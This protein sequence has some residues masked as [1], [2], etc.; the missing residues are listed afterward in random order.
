MTIRELSSPGPTTVLVVDDEEPILRLVDRVLK[1]A[2][3]VTR[4]ASSGADALAIAEGPGPLDV[5][6]TDMMMPEMNGD[7]VA[8]R[9]RLKHPA[10]QVLYCTGY[11]DHLFDEKGAMWEGEAFLE[12]PCG[13]KALLEAVSLLC[14]RNRR[15]G[16]VCVGQRL[17]PK[18]GASL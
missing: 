5:L 6:V 7:E 1:R 2:G 15:I 10:L 9:L 4:L 8:R 18:A 12:K 3:Y 13:P 11:S 14:N 16:E 17:G